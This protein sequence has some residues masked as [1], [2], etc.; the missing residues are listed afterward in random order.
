MITKEQYFMILKLY[1]E[2]G[3]PFLKKTKKITKEEFCNYIGISKTNYN[4]Y[5]KM[6]SLL[7][8]CINVHLFFSNQKI[9]EVNIDKLDELIRKTFYFQ[10]TDKFIFMSTHGLAETGR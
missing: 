1:N 3:N 5:L 8:N 9:L 10:L 7:S 6:V 4:T 2:L